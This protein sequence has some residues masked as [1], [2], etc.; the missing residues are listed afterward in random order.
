[1]VNNNVLGKNANKDKHELEIF[2][3][4]SPQYTFLNEYNV[5]EGMK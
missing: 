2:E 5:S 4:K 3:I 1:M